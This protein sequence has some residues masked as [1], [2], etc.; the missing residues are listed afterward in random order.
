MRGFVQ[1]SIGHYEEKALAVP[2]PARGEVVLRMRA[3]LTCGTDLKILARGHPRIRLP[4]TMGHEFAGEIAAVGPEVTAWKVGDRVVPGISGPCGRCA[5]CLGGRA[6]LC[7]A[8]HAD[9]AWGAFAEQVRIPAGVV[10]ANLHRIPEGLDAEIAAFL[11]PLASV[12]HGWNRLRAPSGTLLVYGAGALAFLWAAV[13][14]MHGLEVVIAGRRADRSALAARYGARFVDLTRQGPEAIVGHTG[15]PADVAVDCTGEKTVWE[16]LPELVRPGGQVLLFGGCA[17]GTAVAF[18]AARLHYAEIA[19]IGAFHY[20]PAEARSALEALAA[21][22]IDPRPLLTARGTLDDVPRFLS[23]QGRG[24][25]VRYAI[26]G[27]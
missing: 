2:A 11:D 9:R 23:E 19:L 24:E 7:A 22:R 13:G 20:S 1:T 3:A 21:G 25:G 10:A 5:D 15:A 17:P 16:L 27:G 8:G 18:D 12:L 6:N 26:L 14:K 4:L